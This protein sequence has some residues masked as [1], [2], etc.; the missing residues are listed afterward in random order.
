[1]SIIADIKG[2]K[3]RYEEHVSR[4]KCSTLVPCQQR[5]GLWLEYQDTAGR[6]GAEPDD[7]TRQREHYNRNVKTGSSS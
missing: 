7:D 4:H 2:A 6:W 3:A 5:A 1:M